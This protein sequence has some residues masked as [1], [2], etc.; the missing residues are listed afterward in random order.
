MRP[1]SSTRVEEELEVDFTM[2]RQG[3]ALRS[4]TPDNRPE[5]H[6]FKDQ[7]RLPCG[8]HL[9]EN[10]N[11]SSR[12][13][14]SGAGARAILARMGWSVEQRASAPD[15]PGPGRGIVHSYALTSRSC[16]AGFTL[17]GAT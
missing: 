9:V 1:V 11:A 12:C 5:P 16:A 13:P 7:F 6:F 15:R 14:N 2:G 3:A 10:G 4:G 8:S 17:G